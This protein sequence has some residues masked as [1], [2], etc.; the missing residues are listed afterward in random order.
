MTQRIIRLLHR[1]LHKPEAP[2]LGR[3]QVMRE[4]LR[5]GEVR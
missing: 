2:P 5:K 3:N 1:L 4:L